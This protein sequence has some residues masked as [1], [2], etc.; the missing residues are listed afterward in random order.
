MDLNCQYNSYSEEEQSY[1]LDSFITADE[2]V[3]NDAIDSQENDNLIA[4]VIALKEKKMAFSLKNMGALADSSRYIIIAKLKKNS[5]EKDILELGEKEVKFFFSVLHLIREDECE[6]IINNYNSEKLDK[7]IDV[8]SNHIDHLEKKDEFLIK[9]LSKLND[10]KT[11]AEQHSE[12][13]EKI[14]KVK[15]S[16]FSVEFDTKYTDVLESSVKVKEFCELLDQIDAVFCNVK[17]F[18][19]NEAIACE[20]EDLLKSA[21]ELED[22]KLKVD[23]ISFIDALAASFESEHFNVEHNINYIAKIEEA[24]TLD[25]IENISHELNYEADELSQGSIQGGIDKVDD[26]GQRRRNKLAVM[27]TDDDIRKL[28]DF[29]SHVCDEQGLQ[30]YESRIRLTEIKHLVSEKT[31]DFLADK[32]TEQEPEPELKIK[33]LVDSLNIYN[34][35]V[36]YDSANDKELPDHLVE[37]LIIALAKNINEK[38]YD[39]LLSNVGDIEYLNH[40]VDLDTFLQNKNKINFKTITNFFKKEKVPEDF[41]KYE[42]IMLKHE[43][44]CENNENVG[45]NHMSREE[46]E[47]LSSELL[48]IYDYAMK[49]QLMKTNE[50]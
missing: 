40:L 14:N 44:L 30:E 9:L 37:D 21:S 29:E 11:K 23:D 20:V 28:I 6:E 27:F 17:R 10:R 46:L 43:F 32:F 2:S 19:M 50:N 47:S 45:R 42:S 8:F 35:L 24:K 22:L 18:H 3:R 25:D 7:Y 41:E 5:F 33:V 15:I 1:Y 39:I 26:A 36:A 34:S 31:E 13:N 16:K 4:I 12:L 48:P 49:K 38:E